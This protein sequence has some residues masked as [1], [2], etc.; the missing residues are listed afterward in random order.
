MQRILSWIKYDNRPAVLATIIR[1]E[2]HAYRK[3]GAAMLF[4]GEEERVGSISPG[5]LEADLQLRAAD[6]WRE[7]VS[8]TAVYDASD[9]DDLS[10]GEA[11]GCGGTIHVLL[12]PVK[13]IFR[14]LLCVIHDRLQRGQTSWLYRLQGESGLRYR[15]SGDAELRDAAEGDGEV[16]LALRIAPPP[17][18][19]L[20]GAGEDVRPIASLAARTGFRIAV[21]DWRERLAAREH[22]PGAHIVS[23]EMEELVRELAIGPQDY[24]LVCSHQ[25]QR[26]QSFL[27]A[28]LEAGPHYVGVIGS[29]ARARRLREA[30]GSPPALRGPVGVDIGAEGAEEIAVSIVADLIRARRARQA[31]GHAEEGGVADENR[32]RIVGSGTQPSGS[33]RDGGSRIVQG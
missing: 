29:R 6:V 5:C 33:V 18:L 7:G 27:A 13:G 22:F 31:D 2:G 12:E 4:A 17:R 20:F 28:A 9:A 26:D 3:A 24:V 8:E 21:A 10:W 11:S 1:V 19:V 23:G 14:D 32:G 16:L 25:L 30:L 15:L